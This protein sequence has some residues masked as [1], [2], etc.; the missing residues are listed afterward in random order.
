MHR[1][2][3]ISDTLLQMSD[4]PHLDHLAGATLDNVTVQWRNGTAIVAF[5]PSAK[6][7]EGYAIRIEG[8]RRLDVTRGAKASHQVTKATEVS[9]HHVE[10]LMEGGEKLTIEAD[11]ILLIG[12]GG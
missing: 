1:K 2:G 3:G 10:L 9:K 8:L 7:S 6:M 12:N 5:L 4:E 11:R